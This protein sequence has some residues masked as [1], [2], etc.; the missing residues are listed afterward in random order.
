MGID[1]LVVG[2]SAFT[3]RFEEPAPLKQP[4]M[5]TGNMRGNSASLSQFPNAKPILEKHLKDP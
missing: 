3:E 4:E 5:L 1:H 2:I